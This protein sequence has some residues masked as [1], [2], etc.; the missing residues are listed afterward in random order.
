MTRLRPD[1]TVTNGSAGTMTFAN[2]VRAVRLRTSPGLAAELVDYLH[3]P[4]S[5]AP[6]FDLVRVLAALEGQGVLTAD[7]PQ[8]DSR[9]DR[10]F[11]YFACFVADPARKLALLGRAH[12]LILG[13]GGTGSV[14]L[15]HLVAAGVGS[16]T[17]VD[18]DEVEA[19]NL[20]RQFIYTL[21]DVDRA[22]VDV[23]AEYVRARSP[24]ARCAT[25]LARIGEAADLD[26]L[27]GSAHPPDVVLV[28]ID[29]PI[30]SIIHTV[31]QRLAQTH[32]PY[33]VAGVGVRYGSVGEVT[34]GATDSRSFSATTAALSTTNA[35]SASY[36]AH[37]IVEW[38]T[39]SSLAFEMRR[40]A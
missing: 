38:L 25:S 40:H 23:C 11:E 1:W 27:V 22:K 29:Q 12:V 10:T 15:Q 35:I 31:T 24:F 16:F 39:G 13:L 30:E 3:D 14:V 18:S 7:K 8:L 2:E 19:S 33:I 28:A 37:A 9:C 32:T 36:A 6:S 21:R 34:V 4:G 5:S 17:L 20:N 26:P